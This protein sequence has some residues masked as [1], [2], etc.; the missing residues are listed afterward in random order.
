MTGP[1][2]KRR[3][4]EGPV[5][6]ESIVPAEDEGVF[7]GTHAEEE[8]ELVHLPALQTRPSFAESLKRMKKVAHEANGMLPT[9]LFLKCH[10]CYG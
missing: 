5:S 1:P 10:A 7:S 3:K 8:E 9:R 2:V 6:S 4:V